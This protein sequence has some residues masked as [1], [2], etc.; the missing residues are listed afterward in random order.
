M[1]QPNKKIDEAIRMINSLTKLT[2]DTFDFRAKRVLKELGNFSDDDIYSSSVAGTALG[3][4]GKH[5]ESL[6]FFEKATSFIAKIPNKGFNEQIIDFIETT[7][8]NYCANLIGCHRF[9]ESERVLEQLVSIV[10]D[11]K[12]Y[13][14]FN[15]IK[16]DLFFESENYQKCLEFSKKIENPDKNDFDSLNTTLISIFCYIFL[17]QEKEALTQYF[18]LIKKKEDLAPSLPIEDWLNEILT[19]DGIKKEP[20]IKEK[21]AL[22]ELNEL[23]EYSNKIGFE[24]MFYEDTFIY[25][26]KEYKINVIRYPK[27]WYYA[28]LQNEPK[29]C[30]QNYK[31]EDVI[32]DLKD[33][34][35]IYPQDSKIFFIP[36]KAALKRMRIATKEKSDNENDERDTKDWLESNFYTALDEFY[37]A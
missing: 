21:V 24:N 37:K 28:E 31:I 32:K 18:K 33:Y 35:H 10:G 16:S 27:E 25:E 14:V 7:Y 3:A 26:E 29:I 6:A 22:K 8:L 15:R 20:T 5:D 9:D 1:A 11:I 19:G 4:L 13:D 34:L 30:S 17:Y 2:G 23:Y 12:K 36:G